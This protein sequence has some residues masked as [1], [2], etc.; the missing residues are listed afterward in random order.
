MI[1]YDIEA[2]GDD[3][4]LYFLYLMEERGNS[5]RMAEMLAL[6]QPPRIM[7]DDVMM[8][9][10][11]TISHMYDRDP[12]MTDRLCQLAMKRGYKPKGSDWYNSAVASS[13]ADPAAFINHGQG[14]G[15][16]KQTMERR[17]YKASS[18]VGTDAVVGVETREPEVDPWDKSQ[19]VKLSPKMVE[20][21]RK[22]K[23]RAN[24]DLKRADQRELR[25]SIVDKHGAQ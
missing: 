6:R 14:R 1:P 24:P 11:E 16:I 20:K 8:Q 12:A 10:V 5:Q 7:T 19:Q 2:A 22:Q 21:I 18:G 23:I 3:T 25:E 4:V 9:G 15:H 13:E 17:G